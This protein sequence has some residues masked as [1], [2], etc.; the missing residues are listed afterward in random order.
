MSA[1]AHAA[2]ALFFSNPDRSS[3]T[4]QHLRSWEFGET[5][6]LPDPF[7]FTVKTDK[8]EPWDD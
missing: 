8:W 3:G 6:S 1:V 2:Q 5:I 7:G 4:Y